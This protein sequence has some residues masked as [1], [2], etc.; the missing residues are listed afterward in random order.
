MYRRISMVVAL[1][2][3]LST[4]GAAFAQ[5]A[6]VEQEPA[7]AIPRVLPRSD[8]TPIDKSARADAAVAEAINY[9]GF[10]NYDY[11]AYLVPADASFRS[12]FL[13]Y[14]A[15]LTNAGWSGSEFVI[16][17]ESGKLYALMDRASGTGLALIHATFPEGT[18]LLVI[19]GGQTVAVPTPLP[20]K[21]AVPQPTPMQDM[22]A[23]DKTSDLDAAADG[24]AQALGFGDYTYAAYSVPATTNF[25]DI[26]GYYDAEMA[27]AGWSET[28]LIMELDG[29]NVGAF[30]DSATKTGLAIAYVS[31][32]E[33]AVLLTVFAE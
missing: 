2:L 9:V 30:V 25:D 8:M 3:V 7:K 20:A 33:G 11:E 23:M 28:S 1:A 22:L 18:V 5:A 17:I 27:K 14:D 4:I 21:K 6:P 31:A 24:V 13:Y 19:F 10:A 29:G 16:D 26:F 15:E 12:L 32:G